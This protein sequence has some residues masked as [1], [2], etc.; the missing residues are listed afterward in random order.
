MASPRRRGV[1]ERGGEDAPGA[2]PQ[3]VDVGVGDG[4]HHALG[5][6]SAAH[7]ELRVHAGHDHV[8]AGQHVVVVVE[9]AVLEDVDLDAG[10]DA[11]R[12]QALVQRGDF[13]ELLVEALDAEA[14]GDREA[15]RVVGHDQVLVPEVLRRPGHGLDR[16][17][18]VGPGGVA[19]AVAADG[20]PEVGADA[21]LHGDL[22]ELAQPV[23]DLPVECLADGPRGAVADA[24]E[25]G[26]PAGGM[27][28]REPVDGDVADGVGSVLV[29]ERAA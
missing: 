21:G 3:D 18:A 22:L 7:A 28:A 26:E 12:R 20:G 19:V 6:G 8:E 16:G 27:E 15:R 23:G 5:H 4:T 25:R 29:G 13:V 11:E 14:V 17:A 10:E 9:R 1:A 24:L 2:V